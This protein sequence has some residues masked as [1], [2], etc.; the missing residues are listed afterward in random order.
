MKR[1]FLL[2]AMLLTLCMGASAQQKVRKNF[3]VGDAN[4]NVAYWQGA[5]PNEC[6][7][8]DNS[9]TINGEFNSVAWVF[10][11]GAF[12]EE[13]LGFDMSLYD[14]LV[15]RVASCVG[16]N[17]QF[18]IFDF[19]G[20]NGGVEYLMP[21]DIVEMDEEVEYEID[22]KEDLDYVDGSGQLDLSNIRRFVFWNYWNV[23]GSKTNPDDE[24]YDPDFVDEYPGAD[25]T[26]TLS[27]M[28]LE[29]TLANGE[30]D[31]VDLL[32]ASKPSFTDDFLA[33]EGEQPSWMDNTGMLHMNENAEAGYFF[34]DEPADWSNYKYVVVVPQKPYGDGDPVVRYLISDTDD[35]VFDSGSFRYGFWNRARAAVQ[36]LTLITSTMLD[37]DMYLDDFNSSAIASFKWSLWGGVQTW[38][39]GIAG[40]WLSNTCPTYST[41]F[42]DGTDNTGD[43]VIDNSAE[44]TI[45]T[46]ALPFAGAVCGANVYT[47]AGIDN[48]AEPSELY[49]A[50]YVGIL[51]AGKPYI[52]RTNCDR[53]V[54][55]FRAGA[56]EEAEPKA[57]GALVAD[58]FATY[59][60]EPDKNYLVL[61]ADGDTF[62]AVTGRSKRVN[63]NTAYIDCSKLAE[64][65]EVE[66]GLVLA[67]SGASPFIPTG[68][69]NVESSGRPASQSIY[70]V[71]GQRVKNLTKGS[72]YIS[73]GK[74]FIQK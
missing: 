54:T 70:N 68:I 66:N 45:M 46:I 27:A 37:E 2:I 73:N 38:E 35:N 19:K 25:V 74:K 32:A 72:L 30:K 67:V 6:N 64:A 55:I 71:L 53:N 44:G 40:A 36:D 34:D 16:N 51:E 43:Y 13:S 9:F 52:L 48:A 3:T 1:Q 39:Y 20:V 33:E 26:V 11:N 7:P 31:Y 23:N 8:V 21:D 17:V 15:I 59:Y 28:Y 41:G 10:D 22:L 61:N 57:N 5:T 69:N 29:R 42:G 12:W 65:E 63:S 47:I 62:E 24:N 18:R 56:N 50:P 60:V 58:Q 49:A 14:K 4:F